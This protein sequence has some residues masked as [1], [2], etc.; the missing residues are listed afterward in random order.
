VKTSNPRKLRR[1]SGLRRDQM[2]TSVEE[3][4]WPR[5]GI[6]TSGDRRMRLAVA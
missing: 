1:V 2:Y 6:E 4:G 3:S 5:K